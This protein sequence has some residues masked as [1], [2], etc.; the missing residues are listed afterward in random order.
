[1]FSPR[2]F[3]LISCFFVL[4]TGFLSAQ[5]RMSTVPLSR[6]IHPSARPEYD[7]GAV[8][9]SMPISYAT[10]HLTPAAGLEAFLAEQQ[11]ASSPNFHRW[12]TPEQFRRPLRSE[13][14]RYGQSPRVAR[15]ACKSS[16][17]IVWVRHTK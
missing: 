12:L 14:G 15:I 17:S 10:L 11:T 2:N 4:T 5:D 7:L 3:I 13:Q 9:P 6:H 8:D 16:K 1:M